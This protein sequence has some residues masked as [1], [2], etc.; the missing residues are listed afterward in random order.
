M[1]FIS[2]PVK[3]E[4]GHGAMAN[5]NIGA[6]ALAGMMAFGAAFV[7]PATYHLFNAKGTYGEHGLKPG[8]Q[9]TSSSNQYGNKY[10]SK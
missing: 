9:H 3:S 7:V 2:I 4:L 1:P 10:R 8:A 5:L 6:V